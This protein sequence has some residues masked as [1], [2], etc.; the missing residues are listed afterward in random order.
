MVVRDQFDEICNV[1]RKSEHGTSK[2]SGARC[3]IGRVKELQSSGIVET[4]SFTRE[5][6]NEEVHV[7]PLLIDSA[8]DHLRNG[9]HVVF[10]T[11]DIEL[12]IRL[13]AVGRDCADRL[14]CY[15][16][17][18]LFALEILEELEGDRDEPA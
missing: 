2:S 7:D 8:V 12:I 6:P 14:E 9:E 5:T 18:P 13:Q 11:R 3:A 16:R 15:D 4:S 17:L 1:K 10:I